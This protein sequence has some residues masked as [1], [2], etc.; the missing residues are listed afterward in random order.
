MWIVTTKGFY[1]VVCDKKRPDLVVVRTRAREDL[2]NLKRDHL[3]EIRIIEGG[4]TDYPFRSYVNR[5]RWAR[6]AF[7]LADEIDYFNFKDAIQERQGKRRHDVYFRVW[8]ALQDLMPRRLRWW[9]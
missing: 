8:I 2:V 5:E 6:A 9:D 7:D 3:P 4:G 1:S